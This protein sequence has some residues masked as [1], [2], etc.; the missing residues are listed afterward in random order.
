[1]VSSFKWSIGRVFSLSYL[2][3]FFRNFRYVDIVFTF[4][5]TLPKIPFFITDSNILAYYYFLILIFY[6]YVLYSPFIYSVFTLFILHVNTYY[7]FSSLFRYCSLFIYLHCLVFIYNHFDFSNSNS[8][9]RIPVVSEWAEGLD[10]ASYVSQYL[11]FYWDFF[12]VTL[13]FYL[14]LR[15]YYESPLNSTFILYSNTFF[16]QSNKF[17][18]NFWIIFFNTWFFRF[19][20]YFCSY[21]FFGGEGF[22]GDFKLFGVTRFCVELLLISQRFFFYLKAYAG[23]LLTLN[24]SFRL[25]RKPIRINFNIFQISLSLIW[26]H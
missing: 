24:G 26:K 14:R 10:F 15:F 13:V 23:A 18:H 4:L 19:V 6:S 22:S 9:L 20:C 17:L 3:F 1:M 7:S 16:I 5:T 21:Y 25:L 2:C 11:G 12:V 8:N